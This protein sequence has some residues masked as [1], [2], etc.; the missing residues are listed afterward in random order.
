M[1]T[2][3]AFFLMIFLIVSCQLKQ[4]ESLNEAIIKNA[5]DAK[6]AIDDTIKVTAIFWI[7]K[8]KYKYAKEYAFRTIKAKVFIHENG[9]VDLLEFVKEQTPGVNKYI[10][11][12][13]AKFMVPPIMFEGGYIKPGEQI[14]QL[15]CLWGDR[16]K[17]I[18]Q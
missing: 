2:I 4:K 14:V 1:K 16:E 6:T 5:N 8:A 11:H 7:D 12:Y 15:R 10:R 17:K 9:K 13:L 18:M 3:L